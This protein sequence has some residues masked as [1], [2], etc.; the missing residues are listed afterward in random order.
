MKNINIIENIK[1]NYIAFE[2]SR[3]I[4]R[5]PGEKEKIVLKVHNYKQQMARLPHILSDFRP[6]DAQKL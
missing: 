5:F 3:W 2:P 6:V 4:Y 1:N